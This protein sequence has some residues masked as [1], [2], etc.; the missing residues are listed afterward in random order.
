MQY[1][2]VTKVTVREEYPT[3]ISSKMYGAN[4]DVVAFNSDFIT[5]RSPM[6]AVK[7]MELYKEAAQLKE[8][9]QR[10]P[11]EEYEAAVKELRKLMA[12]YSELTVR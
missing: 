2:K 11:K 12:K 4:I 5:E 9:D 8:T 1:G 7:L 3:A 6:L 10:A